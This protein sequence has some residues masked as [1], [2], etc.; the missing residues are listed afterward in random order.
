VPRKY[1]SLRNGGATLLVVGI[2]IFLEC[3]YAM[4]NDLMKDFIGVVG[5]IGN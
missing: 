4:V 2:N 5:K 3:V 1:A